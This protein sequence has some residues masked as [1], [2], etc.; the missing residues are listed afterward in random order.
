MPDARRGLLLAARDLF[1]D[2][3]GLRTWVAV[4]GIEVES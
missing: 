4:A 1:V 2:G 3:Y